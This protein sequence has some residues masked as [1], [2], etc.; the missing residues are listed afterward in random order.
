MSQVLLLVGSPKGNKSSSAAL[1]N[2]LLERLQERGL[3]TETVRIYTALKS[4]ENWASLASA[5]ER[6][7]LLILACPLYVDSA[8]APVIRALERIAQERQMARPKRAQSLLAIVNCG[9]PE[10]QHNDPAIALYRRFARE[11]GFE[12][13]GGLSLGGGGAIDGRPLGGLGGMVRNVTKSLDLA[14]D[15]LAEGKP[16]SR[17]AQEAMSRPIIPAWLYRLVGGLGWRTQ[18]RRHGVQKQLGARPF[19]D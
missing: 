19:V 7:D 1:G 10:A 16:V 11:A 14:A 4:E 13:A 15:D 3:E 18:A 5:V 17:E 8:P 9:F 12:W 6:A 2:Y